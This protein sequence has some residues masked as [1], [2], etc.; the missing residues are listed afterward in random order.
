MKNLYELDMV[1]YQ[2][3]HLV[4]Y[5][6]NILIWSRDICATQSMNFLQVLLAVDLVWK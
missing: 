2:I 4:G 3:L 5:Q 6:R 1:G